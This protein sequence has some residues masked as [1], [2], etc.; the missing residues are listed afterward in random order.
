M[1]R[2]FAALLALIA[3]ESA[4]ARDETGRLS[5]ILAPNNAQPA[6]LQP[7]GTIQAV[8]R[9]NV[10]L[11]IESEAGSVPLEFRSA[12]P[13][14]G[15]WVITSLVPAAAAPGPHTLIAEGPEVRDEEFRAV[16]VLPAR[17]ET[18]R[19]AHVSNLRAGDP[20][21]SDTR[22]FRLTA[23]LNAGAPDLILVTG[24]LTAGGTADQFR[25]ALDVLNDCRAP[26]LVAPGEA[27]NAAGLLEAYLGEMPKA[28]GYGP[29]GYLLC[30]PPSGHTPGAE[31]RLHVERR[32]IRS[33]RWSIGV[34]AA[35]PSGDLRSA[36]TVFVDD[37]LDYLF[38]A[39]LD[40]RA[41]SVVAWGRTRAFAGPRDGQIQWITVS[42]PGIAPAQDQSE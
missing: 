35:L 38:Q 17:P 32:A 10:P 1:T 34:A 40:D 39:D 22:L 24:D 13:W 3:A 19:L 21:R 11:R 7:G 15:R 8:L 23:E 14:H 30:P 29:D 20:R 2:M 28:A 33:A 37:P 18:Y 25:V 41:E 27:D 16:Y 42:P 5:L 4:Y 6:L 9:E 31:A 26:T 36:L 12:Q